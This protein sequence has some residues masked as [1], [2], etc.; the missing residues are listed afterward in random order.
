MSHIDARVEG[1]AVPRPWGACVPKGFQVRDYGLPGEQWV[2]FGLSFWNKE[3][4]LTEL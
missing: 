4:L 3:E 1:T 2:E